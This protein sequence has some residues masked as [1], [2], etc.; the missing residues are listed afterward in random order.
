MPA[1]ASPSSPGGVDKH[2]YRIDIL[3]A[4]RARLAIRRAAPKGTT[5]LELRQ[6]PPLISDGYDD[7]YRDDDLG[8]DFINP[9]DAARL[10]QAART[11]RPARRRIATVTIDFGSRYRSASGRRSGNGY[12]A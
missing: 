6:R 7:W 4:K 8:D 3:E 11:P 9:F 10:D 5:S 2:S 1:A 12:Y